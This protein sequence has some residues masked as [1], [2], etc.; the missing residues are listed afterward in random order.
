MRIVSK[1]VSVACALSVLTAA[2]PAQA[3]VLGRGQGDFGPLGRVS[4]GGAFAAPMGFQIFCLRT[5]PRCTA[6]A[7]I[8]VSL[9]S[10]LFELLE[11]VNREVNGAIRPRVRESQIW[12]LGARV[13]DCKDYAMNKWNRLIEMGVPAGA[14]RLAI[15]Y[16]KDGIGHAV[17]V[18]RTAQGD[19]VLDNLTNEILAW[20]E[21]THDLI[22]MSTSN[23]RRWTVV[24]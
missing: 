15:G 9:T 21:V 6:A 19:L 17:V 18:V 13:G 2:L 5:P 12:E 11:R 20:N 16:T 1:I 3:I 23:P 10:D 7:N 24:S 4:T 8:E 14:L 22:A